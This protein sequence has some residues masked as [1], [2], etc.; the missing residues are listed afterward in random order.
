M[1]IIIDYQ[2][3]EEFECLHNDCKLLFNLIDQK[4]RGFIE[5]GDFIRPGLLSGQ[6]LE[7]VLRETVKSIT[8]HLDNFEKE[9]VILL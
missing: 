9:D 7:S 2:N 4:K 8:N 5:G 3:N 1:S 6:S